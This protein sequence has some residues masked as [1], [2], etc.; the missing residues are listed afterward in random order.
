MLGSGEGIGSLG[1]G[2]RELLLKGSCG[3][4]VGQPRQES[5]LEMQEWDNEDGRGFP[6]LSDTKST[7]DHKCEF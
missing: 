3:G 7:A 6:G 5:V 2:I 4:L 1:E